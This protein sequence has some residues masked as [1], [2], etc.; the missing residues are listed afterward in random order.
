MALINEGNLGNYV[1][2]AK[3]IPDYRAAWNRWLVERYRDRAALAAAWKSALKAGEDPAQGTVTLDGSV[4]SQDLRGRDLVLF[5]AQVEQDFLARATAFLRK[6]LG[7]RALVTNMNGWT[8]HATSQQVRSAMDYVDDHFYVDH[9]RFL[10]QPWRLPSRCPNTSPVAGGASG[11]RHLA[12]TRLFDKPFTVTEYNYSGPGRYRGVGGILTGALGAIQGWDAI[13]RFAYSHSRDN[14]FQPA[15]LDYFNMATDP[16]GQAAERASL[17]LFLRGDM[18]QAP[19]SVSIAMTEDDFRRPP[20]QIPGL[21]PSWHWAAWLTRVG[22]RVVDDPARSLPHDLVLPLGWATPARDFTGAKA[23]QAGDPYKLSEEQLVK[24]L[25]QRGILAA[26]NP[27]D[28]GKNV[29]QC[30]TAEIT[31]DGPRDRLTLDTPRTAGGFAPAGESIRTTHGV[32]IAVQDTDATV[33]V[34]AL[35]DQPITRS[36]RLLVTHLTDLQN[37]DIRYAERARQTLLDW[38]KL[39]HLVRAGKAEVRVQLNEPGV[40]RVWALSTSGK[41]LAEV[42]SRKTGGELAF[43]ADVAGCGEQGAVLCYEIISTIGGAGRK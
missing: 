9:P 10:E 34:S 2:L 18:R 5:L 12:F 38:G 19:H 13:W 43:T 24:L 27:T 26:S 7:A 11:G 36:R 35:D 28:P 14:L 37:T 16:L 15:K 1:S 6:D 25:R 29:F 22:T 23:A 39:P 17:C 40:Y 42:A 41:R 8:N 3:D 4:H 32:Q 33:W 21:A 30:E 20:A 31:I